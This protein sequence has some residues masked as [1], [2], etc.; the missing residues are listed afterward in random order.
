MRAASSSQS[1]LVLEA[2]RTHRDGG[3]GR[4]RVATSATLAAYVLPAIL[5]GPA[6]SVI[7]ASRWPSRPDRPARCCGAWPT[8]RPTSPSSTRRGR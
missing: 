3:W 5:L 1:D 7:R 4:V 8:T 6:G 2:M